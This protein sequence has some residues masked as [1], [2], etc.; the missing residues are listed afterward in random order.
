[1]ALEKSQ[2]L[3]HDKIESLLQRVEA[4]DPRVQNRIRVFLQSEVALERPLVGVLKLEK[5][6]RGARH[7]GAGPGPPTLE[8]VLLQGGGA[9][10]I[11]IRRNGVVHVVQP[12]LGDF[13]RQVFEQEIERV[14]LEE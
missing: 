10:R 7:R 6:C 3:V 14:A 13:V 1:M 4:A 12:A 2:H 9:H 5:R 11:V 8:P